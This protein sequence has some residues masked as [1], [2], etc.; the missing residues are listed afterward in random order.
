MNRFESIV[1]AN[2]SIRMPLGENEE[3]KMNSTSP[4]V[5]IRRK[6]NVPSDELL[7]LLRADVDN[8]GKHHSTTCARS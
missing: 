6:S 4:R 5:V 3:E 7:K 2:E 1:K 8:R